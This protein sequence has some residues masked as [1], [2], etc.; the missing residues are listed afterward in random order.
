MKPKNNA[1][2]NVLILIAGIAFL[3]LRGNVINIMVTI[4]GVLFMVSAV[5]NVIFMFTSKGSSG[6]GSN[7][8]GTLVCI[9]AFALGL[10]M[11]L[12]PGALVGIIVYLLAGLLVLGGIYHIYMIAYGYR[13]MHFPGWFYI[14]PTLLLAAGVVMF[15]MGPENVK[16]YLVLVT[17]IALIV[18]A[19]SSFLEYAGKQSIEKPESRTIENR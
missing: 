13:P 11:T 2:V 4:M 6:T 5:V 10:W 16:N 9:A 1:L 17:G 18:F 8:A 7:L 12:A 3:F 15:V 14:L 19:I